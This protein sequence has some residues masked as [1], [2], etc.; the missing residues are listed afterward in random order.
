M[1]IGQEA[2]AQEVADATT[3]GKVADLPRW[4]RPAEKLKVMQTSPAKL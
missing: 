2:V 1:E 4:I 3:A